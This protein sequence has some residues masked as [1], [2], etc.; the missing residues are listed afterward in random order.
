[1]P[2]LLWRWSLLNYFPRVASDHHPLHLASKA[3]RV[4]GR[5]HWCQLNYY[6]EKEWREWTLLSH[7]WCERKCF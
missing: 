1:L 5:S 3:A 7:F 2:S 4:I 6:F